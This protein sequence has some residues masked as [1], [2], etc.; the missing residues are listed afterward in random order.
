MK[1]AFVP[2]QEL[3][4]EWSSNSNKKLGSWRILNQFFWDSLFWSCLKISLQLTDL[5]RRLRRW[6]RWRLRRFGCGWPTDG[7][8]C[9]PWER[10]SRELKKRLWPKCRE[11][12]LY[13]SGCFGTNKSNGNSF[14]Q[15]D[16]PVKYRK[17]EYLHS[18]DCHIPK[19]RENSLIFVSSPVDLLIS[20]LLMVLISTSYFRDVFIKLLFFFLPLYLFLLLHSSAPSGHP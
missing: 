2:D 18:F 7:K 9:T 8:R 15:L 3:V 5:R 16:A 17:P 10:N 19:S 11:T 13:T 20:P 1:G 6:R 12:S 4:S 14:F